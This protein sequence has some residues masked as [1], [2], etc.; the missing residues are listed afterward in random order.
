MPKRPVGHVIQSVY[1]RCAT[2]GT[3]QRTCGTRANTKGSHSNWRHWSFE[4][5]RCLIRLDCI[6]GE[7]GEQRW[8]AIG[9]A[10]IEPGPAAVLLVV[11]AYREDDHGEEIIRIISARR[12]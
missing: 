6:D 9:R 5:E 7:T 12:A 11:H 10:H 3:G 2:N 8:R 4:D 1:T